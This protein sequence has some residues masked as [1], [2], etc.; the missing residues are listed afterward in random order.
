V[1]RRPGPG[2]LVNQWSIAFDGYELEAEKGREALC[3]LGNGYFATRGAA[4]EA[5]AGTHLYPGTYVAGCY[6]RLMDEVE[7]RLIENESLVNLPNWLMQRV[8]VGDGDWFAPVAEDIEAFRQVARPGGEG[9]DLRTERTTLDPDAGQRA[10]LAADHEERDPGQVSDEHRSG[11]RVR[12]EAEAG[13]PGE[14]ADQAHHDGEGR[15]ECGVRL[16]ITGGDRS[17]GG[18]R[19]QSRRRL[20]A[21]R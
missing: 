16:G 17:D 6:N 21:D 3:T 9:R 5:T 14:Q 20:R 1:L 15:R 2:A 13:G 11:Q 10:Q 4:P 18:R 8:A 7:G 12:Q 19:E